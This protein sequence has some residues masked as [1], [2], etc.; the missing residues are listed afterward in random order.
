MQA[1]IRKGSKIV[2]VVVFKGDTPDELVRVIL[3]QTPAA[4]ELETMIAREPVPY[5]S[6][7]GSADYFDRTNLWHWLTWLD[8]FIRR[9]GLKMSTDGIVIPEPEPMERVVPE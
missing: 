4:D 8:E 5:S 7:F 3:S 2:L 1:I 6:Y 9:E